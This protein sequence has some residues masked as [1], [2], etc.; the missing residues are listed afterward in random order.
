M[1]LCLTLGRSFLSICPQILHWTANRW[2]QEIGHSSL[3]LIWR[4]I[5]CFSWTKASS[6]THTHTR[7]K[8][9][10]T[11]TYRG[12]LKLNLSLLDVDWNTCAA[13]TLQS[14]IPHSNLLLWITGFNVSGAWNPIRLWS[15]MSATE[16]WCVSQHKHKHTRTCL[17]GVLAEKQT[18]GHESAS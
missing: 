14:H 5:E 16:P 11:N 8:C 3:T 1:W 7:R 9:N 12:K 17:P 6:Y 18:E 13:D 4:T 10:L 15:N 2:S